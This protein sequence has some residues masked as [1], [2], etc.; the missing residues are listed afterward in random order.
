MKY[1]YNRRR[2]LDLNMLG[3]AWRSFLAG[4]LL[5]TGLFF[6]Y[7]WITGGLK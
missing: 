5:I 7:F 2:S 4:V 6:I 3:D 1:R